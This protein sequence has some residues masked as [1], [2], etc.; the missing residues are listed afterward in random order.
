MPPAASA[1]ATSLVLSAAL[2]V[3]AAYFA[4]RQWRDRRDRDPDLSDADADYFARQDARRWLGSVVMVLLAAGIAF[5]TRINPRAN[6]EAGRLFGWV[7]IGVIVL[8]F[9]WLTLAL[10]DW[11]AIAAY[12]RRHREALANERYA[13]LEEERRKRAARGNGRGGPHGPIGDAPR[14]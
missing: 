9:I 11:R 10:L 3:L 5:G 4:V 2:L 7:W 1:A 13:A 14:H 12:A 8:L 6:R